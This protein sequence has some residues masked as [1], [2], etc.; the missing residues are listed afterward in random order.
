ML[1]IVR[2]YLGTPIVP[3]I[4]HDLTFSKRLWKTVYLELELELELDG[5]EDMKS[6][7]FNLH[8]FDSVE[9]STQ[10]MYS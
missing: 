2:T 5:S 7:A 8:L 3:G 4:Y 1:S 6:I 9:V 10:T